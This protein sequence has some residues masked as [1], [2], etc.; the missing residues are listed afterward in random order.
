MYI[1]WFIRNLYLLIQMT[2]VHFLYIFGFCPQFL[3]PSSQD[4]GNF[5]S[6]ES[7]TCISCHVEKVTFGKHGRMGAGLEPPLD[8]REG[9]AESWIN[10][11]LANDLITHACARKPPK[12]PK[13]QGSKSFRIGEHIEILGEWCTP[14]KSESSYQLKSTCFCM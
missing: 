2:K 12:N 1:G 10:H 14:R 4:P 5:L 8:L 7:N 9:R 3:A 11:Q 13:E 6:L